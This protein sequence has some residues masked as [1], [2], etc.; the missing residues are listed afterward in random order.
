MYFP[1][2]FIDGADAAYF[3]RCF[4]SQEFTTI[5]FLWK[6]KTCF[7]YE[8]CRCNGHNNYTALGNVTYF[9]ESK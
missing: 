4:M 1:T 8:Y 5:H 6:A 3:I 2:L 7:I 9:N